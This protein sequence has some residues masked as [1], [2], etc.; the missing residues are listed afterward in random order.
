VRGTL[1]LAMFGPQGYAVIMGQLAL[2]SLIVQASSPWLVAF[3][4]THHSHNAFFT[5]VLL[6]AAVNMVAVIALAVIRARQSR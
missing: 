1:P 3:L 4:L 6:L 5:T 2:P